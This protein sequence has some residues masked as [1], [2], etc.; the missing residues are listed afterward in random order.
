[1]IHATVANAGSTVIKNFRQALQTLNKPNSK[2]Y[3]NQIIFNMSRGKFSI[4]V[5][6]LTSKEIAQLRAQGYKVRWVWSRR[7]CNRPEYVVSW[8]DV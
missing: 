8:T 1:M 3:E 5:D 4:G 7:F 6:G 2:R